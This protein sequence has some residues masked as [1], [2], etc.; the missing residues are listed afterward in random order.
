V[1]EWPNLPL[2]EAVTFLDSRRRPVKANDRVA[3]PYPYYGAN[4]Q[5]G[6]I[7]GFLFDE[8]LVLLAED[9]GHFD[10]PQRGI[11][12]LISGKT[13]VNNHAHVLRANNGFIP[14]FIECQLKHR[15]IRA[16]ITGTTRGKLTKSDA[17]RILI[18]RPPINEQRRIVDILD[19]AASIRRLR[20]QARETARQIVPALFNQMFGDPMTNPMAWPVAPLETV[21]NVASGV[22]K[23]RRLN[24]AEV[25]DVPYMR[26]ANVQDGFLDLGEVKTIPLR[27]SEIDRFRLLPGDMLMTEGGDPDKL[28]RG[29]IWTGQIPY[30]AHQNHVFR[31]RADRNRMLPHFLACLSGSA[32][33]KGYFLRVAKRTTGIASINK[34][35]LSAFPVLL[36]PVSLQEEF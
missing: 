23:G 20:R 8:P 36:P 17:S 3:G 34:T 28:G 29:A 18:S 30:C 2:G 19:R 14:D 32:Y 24:A 1:S 11:A 16:Y 4:G 33:G 9:G 31:V 5:Q 35:Q 21:A 25:V 7:D 10:E 13:W 6:T 12:Y 15:D 26:V 27:P 22:T